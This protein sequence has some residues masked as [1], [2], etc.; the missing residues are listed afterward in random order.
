MTQSPFIVFTSI[1][2]PE[3][4]RILGLSRSKSIGSFD[5][6]VGLYLKKPNDNDLVQRLGAGIKQYIGGG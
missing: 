1:M 3:I 2:Y 6:A 5:N 4:T